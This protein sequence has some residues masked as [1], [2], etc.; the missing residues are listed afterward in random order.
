V[1]YTDIFKRILRNEI[2]YEILGKVLDV[3]KAVEEEK[4]DQHEGSVLV[5]KV[6]KE[7]YLDSAVRHGNNLDKKYQET[8]PPKPVPV[9][10]KLISWKDYKNQGNPR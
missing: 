9:V 3:L 10:E 2:N 4:V 1:N 8:A 5:G 6:L 7:M